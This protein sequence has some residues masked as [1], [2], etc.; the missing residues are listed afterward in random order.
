MNPSFLSVEWRTADKGTGLNRD[1]GVASAFALLNCARRR[2]REMRCT[3]P[4]NR[5]G[6]DGCKA[7]IRARV[8]PQ[9]D[10]GERLAQAH[11]VKRQH[12]RVQGK[13]RPQPGAIPIRDKGGITGN[14]EYAQKHHRLRAKGGEHQA[15]R[16]KTK[17]VYC[18]HCRSRWRE[19]LGTSISERATA[20]DAIRDPAG[21]R[22]SEARNNADVISVPQLRPSLAVISMLD[23]KARAALRSLFKGLKNGRGSRR[24]LSNP[25][26]SEEISFGR[27]T[28]QSGLRSSDG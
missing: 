15:G 24:I 16:H 2:S 13:N 11:E 20:A 3:G 7:G 27:L 5:H 23:S 10:G 26:D 9:G 18:R 21:P 6:W 4:S 17:L 14:R 22:S 28:R 12:H 25:M 1:T 8:G 19:S